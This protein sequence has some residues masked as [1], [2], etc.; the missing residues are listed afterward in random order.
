MRGRLRLC[1]KQQTL[2]R[3][4]W[5]SVAETR[6]HGPL[7]RGF[8][9]S[10]PWRNMRYKLCVSYSEIL[11]AYQVYSPPVPFCAHRAHPLCK[12][13]SV[14]PA[15]TAPK[16]EK[17]KERKGDVRGRKGKEKQ[18]GQYLH[19]ISV[20][21]KAGICY[22]HEL[23]HA[24][25]LYIFLKLQFIITIKGGEERECSNFRFQIIAICPPL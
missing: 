22:Q 23:Y 11:F 17:G 5:I 9:L 21:L 20:M 2:S 6:S 16:G 13:I 19:Q 4:L 24:K 8:S 14:T 1:N 12:A 10:A 3:T 7:Q 15:C 18:G 25:A